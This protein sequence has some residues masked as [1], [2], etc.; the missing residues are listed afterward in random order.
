MFLP[1]NF[2]IPRTVKHVTIQHVC[3]Y[4]NSYRSISIF[5]TKQFL[6]FIFII[7]KH[8][9]TI[10]NQIILT[11][12]SKQ[13][14]S[15]SR[16]ISNGLRPVIVSK[17]NTPKPNTSALVDKFNFVNNSGAMYPLSHVQVLATIKTKHYQNLKRKT[18]EK[19]HA[20]RCEPLNGM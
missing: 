14:L 18:R 15:S 19:K 8:K 5:Q 17:T 7:Y 6:G 13:Y 3:N 12:S 16:L 1:T 4:I 9:S 2:S 10:I 20:S 11:Y